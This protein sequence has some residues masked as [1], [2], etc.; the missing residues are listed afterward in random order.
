MKKIA[1]IVTF[2]ILISKVYCQEKMYIH[3]SNNS[4]PIEYTI[5]SVDSMYFS[6]Y[7]S[8]LYIRNSGVLNLYTIS[9]IDSITF[10]LNI[11]YITYN[12]SSVNVVNPLSS[13]GVYVTVNGANVTV[14]STS[15]MQDIVYCISGTTSNGSL[16]LF[17]DKRCN[18]V[19]NGVSIT[20]TTGPAVNIQ[21]NKKTTVTLVDGTSNY[22][23][24]A[25]IYNNIFS[26]NEDQKAAFFSEGQL[27]F[28]GNG[29]LSVAGIGIDKHAICSDDYIEVNSGNITVISSAKDGIHSKDG[30]RINGGVITVSSTKDAIDGESGIIL[31]NGGTINTVNST[32]DAKGITC[33]S[34]LIINNGI[35][36]FTMS[37]DQSKGLKSKRKMMINGGKININTSGNA[38]LSA[39]GSGYS[40]SYCTAIKCD[41]EISIG[42]AKITIACSGMGGKGIASDKDIVIN[43]DSIEIKTYGNGA[44]FLNSSGVASAYAST[45][46]SADGNI[47]IVNG[48]ISITSSGTGGKGIS[49]DKSITIGEGSNI[50]KLNITTS[51]TRILVSGTSGN[52]NASYEN[53]KALKCNEIL[54]INNCDLTVKT[55]NPGG[56]GLD[57]DSIIN[58]NGGNIS[59]T[60]NGNQTKAI[61][62]SKSINL[63]GGNIN[64]TTTGN[65]V[66]ETSGS[67]NN[68]SYCT[69]IKSNGIVNLNGSSITINASGTAAKGISSNG[70]FIMNGGSANISCTGAGNKYTNSSGVLDSYNST[71]ISSDCRVYIKGG[72]ITTSTSTAAS[73]G[74]GISS[75]GS[76]FIGDSIGVPNISLTT[77][78]AKFLV[79]GTNYC[80]PKTLVSDSSITVLSGNI[81][82][83]STDDGIH[84]EKNFTQ[85]GG[86][87]NILNSVEGVEAFKIEINSGTLNIQ[88]SNDGINGTAGLVAGGTESNDGSQF[89]M[90]GGTLVSNCS[91]GDAVDCN[92]NIYINGGLVIANGPQTGVEEACDFNGSFNMNGGTFIGSGS[93]SN[94]TK[95]MSTTST[96]ANMLIKS[97]TAIPSTSFL[98]IQNSTGGEVLTFKP[99]YGGYYFLFSSP[100]LLKGSTYSIYTGGSYSGGNNNNGLYTG[101]NYTSGTLKKTVTLSTSSTVNTIT[102]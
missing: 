99:K 74:K 8:I 72:S 9:N 19:M 26:N 35:I 17:S 75:N 64:I 45:A 6:S 94:M 31:I 78:G 52:A 10:S 38:V 77:T 80:H 65:V 89:I 21:T 2:L 14:T 69:A 92:G 53:P 93:N 12:G 43:C 18:L 88:A 22:L 96:Q 63:L 85:N 44:T 76:I 11:V 29:T 82:I 95:A 1:F 62:G 27:V 28:E 73:G 20:S 97:S 55:T 71:C 57:C 90:N 86:S 16:R 23:S 42:M 47:N 51:G 54:D 81:T 50:P 79:S 70:D 13:S 39:L 41:E 98:R 87:F 34:N 15:T 56:E 37:G 32:S 40:T 5:S 48:Y 4:T 91:A 30:L 61:K 100:D 67:G 68:P 7:N 59:L 25:S 33:D 66:L 46:I 84:A 60:V 83:S 58:V 3:I 101:G 102:F 49:S 24:D 36:N